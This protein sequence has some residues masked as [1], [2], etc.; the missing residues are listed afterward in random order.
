MVQ[1]VMLVSMAAAHWSLVPGDIT[2]VTEEAANEWVN[3]G[4]AKLYEPP[5]VKTVERPEPLKEEKDEELTAD[6][7]S[8]EQNAQ[9]E[10]PQ[11]EGIKHVGGGWYLL[12]N[13]EKVQGKDEALAEL[14][15]LGDE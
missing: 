8:E 15:K 4:I 13:G 10:D 14:A 1:V 5:E 9:Q 3:A 7:S 2:E 11:D 6:E 12:P